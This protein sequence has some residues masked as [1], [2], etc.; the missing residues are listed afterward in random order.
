MTLEDYFR[1]QTVTYNAVTYPA[2][3]HALRMELCDGY[4]R[5]Y[6]HPS[7]QSGDTVNFEVHG[8]ELRPD[9]L[10]TRGTDGPTST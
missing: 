7:A 10:V 2:I 5:F 3:D 9:R 1:K 8:N 4:V 6:I